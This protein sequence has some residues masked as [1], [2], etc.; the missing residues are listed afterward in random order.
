MTDTVKLIIEIP[1]EDYNKICKLSNA[2]LMRM[3]IFNGMA[4]YGIKT[5]T[6]IDENKCFD[7]MTNGE[8]IQALFP[9]VVFSTGYSTTRGSNCVEVKGMDRYNQYFDPKWIDSPYRR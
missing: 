2:D 3:P 6:L 8:V 1:E 9:S 5:G 4:L 7:G